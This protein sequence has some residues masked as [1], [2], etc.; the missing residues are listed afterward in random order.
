MGVPSAAVV[1]LNEGR[2][3]WWPP[4]KV[5]EGRKYSSALENDKEGLGECPDPVPDDDPQQ[6]GS[7]GAVT[8]RDGFRA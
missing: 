4:D 3:E 8:L 1:I 7:R 6:S 2:G 5:G